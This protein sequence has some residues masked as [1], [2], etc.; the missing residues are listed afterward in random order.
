M[1]LDG[2]VTAVFLFSNTKTSKQNQW[3]QSKTIT[4]KDQA[5]LETCG[6]QA[7]LLSA[8]DAL[9]IPPQ[10]VIQSSR[11]ECHLNTCVPAL[12]LATGEGGTPYEYQWNICASHFKPDRLKEGLRG[13][14][15][16]LLFGVRRLQRPL[17]HLSNY[18]LIL[19]RWTSSWG[20][21]KWW[22]CLI[23]PQLITQSWLKSAA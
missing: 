8:P 3:H 17:N 9:W 4:S 1:L 12:W 7:F 6:E 16:D 5:N 15:D 18:S 23:N 11:R 13:L 10:K 2:G 19:L 14:N 20:M 21:W 22:N